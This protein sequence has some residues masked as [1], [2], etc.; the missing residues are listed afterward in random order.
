[1]VKLDKI[2]PNQLNMS[3]VLGIQ[4]SPWERPHFSKGSLPFSW[5]HWLTMPGSFLLK[6][7]ATACTWPCHP[8]EM[9]VVIKCAHAGT[10]TKHGRSEIPE[11]LG[12]SG[13]P[14]GVVFLVWGQEEREEQ[15]TNTPKTGRYLVGHPWHGM[16]MK[17]PP[18]QEPPHIFI[19]YDIIYLYIYNS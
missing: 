19:W 10:S 11:M 15:V 7:V 13:K 9:V 8:A 3:F 4:D 16:T 1:M 14:L 12:I 18:F 6:L 2:S 17:Y 5:L